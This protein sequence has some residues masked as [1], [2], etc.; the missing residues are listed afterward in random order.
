MSIKKLL[1]LIF[2]IVV[3]FVGFGFVK[4]LVDSVMVKREERAIGVSELDTM[5][6]TRENFDRLVAERTE[7]LG[8]E[9]GESLSEYL[10]AELE[11]ERLLDMTNY[12]ALQS[13]VV[14]QDA[15]FDKRQRSAVTT[16]EVATVKKGTILAP[17]PVPEPDSFSVTVD[18][19]GSYESA[20][21]FL[22]RLTDSGRYGT[23]R[24]FSIEQE[25][26]RSDETGTVVPSELLSGSVTFEIFY[27]PERTYPQAYLLPVFSS[28]SFD[29]A[30]VDRLIEKSGE[31]I[32]P[33]L[34]GDGAGRANPF[35]S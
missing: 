5:R 27:L 19:I 32:P 35:V 22:V 4:P 9:R 12:V 13:G 30:T 14:L 18:F 10:P 29:S 33:M 16:R 15:V 26:E 21:D 25:P 28:G 3:P 20:R 24:K 1:P 34:S 17:P 7:L 11:Q 23:I 8:S 6:R 31:R 2:L